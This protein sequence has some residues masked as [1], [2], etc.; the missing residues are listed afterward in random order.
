MVT[1]VESDR[2]VTA[3]ARPYV[4]SI[5][6]ARSMPNMAP[7]RAQQQRSG[8]C[9]AARACALAARLRGSARH[10][11]LVVYPTRHLRAPLSDTRTL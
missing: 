10:T 1:S 11:G 4:R 7:G 3:P 2:Y 6:R 5:C 8:G 9:G